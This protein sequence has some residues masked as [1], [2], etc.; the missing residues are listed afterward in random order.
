VI[1]RQMLGYPVASVKEIFED[2]QHEAR[3]FWQTIEHPELAT[4]LDYPGGFA[5]FAEGACKIWRRA[6]FIGEHNEE[7]YC[8]ELGLASQ[9]VGK[10]KQEGVI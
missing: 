5:K 1:K 2:P 9:D 3:G 8:G 7:I 4:S 10:L 6:P